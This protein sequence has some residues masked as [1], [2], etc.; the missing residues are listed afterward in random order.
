M[1]SSILQKYIKAFACLNRANTQYGP[2]PH[3][4]ILLITLIELIE[5]GLVPFN[6]FYVNSDLVATFKENWLVLVSTMHNDDF[7]QPFFFLQSEKAEGKPFWFVIPQPGIEIKAVIKS[8]KKLSEACLFGRLEPELFNLLHDKQNRTILKDLLLNQ[9]FS[10]HRE[11]F[12]QAKGNGEGYMNEQIEYILNEPRIVRKPINL[13]EIDVFVRNGLFKKLVPQLYG[14]KCSFT[15]MQLKNTFGYTF[16]DA[17]HI[18]PFSVTH[19]DKISNGLALCPNL[20][21]AF[22]RGLVTVDDSFKIKISKHVLPQEDHP[23]SLAGLD[24]R[25]M[26]LPQEKS[27]HP[28][29]AAL[30]WHRENIYKK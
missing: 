17:C 22:D 2:A 1:H 16:I 27:H 28:D 8:V 24:G 12:L 11:L 3:K 6:E 13:T 26:F 18:V 20:H 4:P 29:P 19:D 5:K 14:N 7:T 15:G 23:Y 25:N 21:R 9:Y 30:Y 10:G